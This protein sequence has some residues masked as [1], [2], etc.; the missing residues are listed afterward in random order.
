MSESDNAEI[1]V[2]KDRDQERTA[3]TETQ[4]LSSETGLVVCTWDSY[5]GQY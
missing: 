3:N 1:N 2:E 5:M 4:D